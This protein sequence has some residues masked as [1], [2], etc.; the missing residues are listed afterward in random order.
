MN[1]LRG[2]CWSLEPWL[3]HCSLVKGGGERERYVVSEANGLSF[4]KPP[5]PRSRVHP[6]LV[7]YTALTCPV[8]FVENLLN[9]GGD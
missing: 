3:P 2:R 5:P 7:L 1:E 8:E 6:S 9:T 4:S